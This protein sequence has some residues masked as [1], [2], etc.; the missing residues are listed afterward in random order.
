MS[1]LIDGYFIEVPVDPPNLLADSVIDR[2]FFAGETLVV[3]LPEAQ[4]VEVVPLGLPG[5]PGPQGP[6]SVLVLNPGDP[7]PAPGD[8][9]PTSL[10]VRIRA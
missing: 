2:S 1:D 5:S 9:T 10:V 3:P 6:P 4:W 8:G 7:A